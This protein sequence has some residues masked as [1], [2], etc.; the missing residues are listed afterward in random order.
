MPTGSLV[1]AQDFQPARDIGTVIGYRFELDAE[2]SG[3]EGGIKL[4]DQFLLGVAFVTQALAPEAPAQQLRVP[5]TVR[6]FMCIDLPL[7]VRVIC[8]GRHLSVR[9]GRP[10]AIEMDARLAGT[11]VSRRW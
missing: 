6:R 8:S 1:V 2:I 11:G 9:G 4:G 5:R 3:Q 10:L 7:S